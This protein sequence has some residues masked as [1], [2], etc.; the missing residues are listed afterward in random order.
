MNA[1]RTFIAAALLVSSGAAGAQSAS[2]AQC[3]IL[4]N[5]FA[6]Q[7]KEADAQK[8]AEASIYFYL[9]RIRDGAT[10]TQL[11]SLFDAQAKTITQA[12]ASTLLNACIKNVQ[13]KQQLVQSIAPK[14]QQPAPPPGR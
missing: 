11:K 6:A 10:G 2:D 14:A 1:T 5:A 9:G 8:A 7:A 3:F 13:E 4:S 12:N